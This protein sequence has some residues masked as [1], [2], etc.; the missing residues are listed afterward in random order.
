M[1]QHPTP[2]RWTYDEFAK[3]PEGDGNRY[4][5]IAGQLYVTPAPA[6]R[7]QR[8]VTDLVF[9]LQ[10]YV[11]Q[12]RLG[13]VYVGPVDVLFAEGDYLEPDLIFISSERREIESARG[14]EAAPD[15][16][17]EVLSPSTA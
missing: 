13:R 5:I 12:H 1:S 4:E 17:V 16:V 3:L 6:M 14:V 15:L 2:T 7:H 11:R 8:V 10:S 9:V